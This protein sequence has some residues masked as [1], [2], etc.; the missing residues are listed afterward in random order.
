[1][2]EPWRKT[3]LDMELLIKL[4]YKNRKIIGYTTSSNYS[5]YYKKNI[6][7][8]YVDIKFLK[9]SNLSLEVEGRKYPLKLE[10]TEDE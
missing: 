3:L 10:N 2:K 9:K 5:F 4:P 6:C 1:M 7:M 8:A